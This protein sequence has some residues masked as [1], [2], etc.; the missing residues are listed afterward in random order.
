MRQR[1]I[2]RDGGRAPALDGA[3]VRVVEGYG[4]ADGMRAALEGVPT[5]FLVPAT[6]AR[7]RVEQHVTAVDAAVAA[8]VR[9]IV[10][11]SILN[12]SPDATFTFAR[13]HWATEEHIRGTDLAFTF[14][15]LSLYLDFVPLMVPPDGVIR[16]PAD[17]GRFAPVL[18]DD[19]ADVAVAVL[20]T[21]GHDGRT[22]DV[23]GGLRFSLAEAAAELS[24]LTGKRIAFVDETLEEAYASRAGFGGEDFEVDGWVTSY[25]A[26]AAGELDVVSDI[27][28]RLAGHDPHNARRLRPRP[29]REPG[30]RRRRLSGGRGRRPP[31][32]TA[33]PAL[34]AAPA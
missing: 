24:G 7:D 6:E 13:D 11:L 22:Y 23:T 8:G 27:V 29:S 32:P 5:L 12:A 10:Y 34:S 26:L 1:L 3:E 4:D 25:L 16:G 2:V 20:T 15:R 14:P 19:L 33:A 30:A 28:R 17:D 21:D 9:R 31:P 18:R